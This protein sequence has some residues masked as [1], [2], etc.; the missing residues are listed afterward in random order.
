[1]PSHRPRL[2]NR[3]SAREDAE[4]ELALEVLLEARRF[5]Q[6]ARKLRDEEPFPDTRTWMRGYAFAA[7]GLAQSIRETIRWH[8]RS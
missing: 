8:A 1:M 5:A 6:A 2:R 7:K 3:G 4:R